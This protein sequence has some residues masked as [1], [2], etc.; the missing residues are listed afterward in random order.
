MAGQTFAADIRKHAD[1]TK[2]QMRRV[3]IDSFQD[4]MELCQTSARGITA[5]GTR[6]EGRI[7]VVSSDL[8]NS[9][10]S[11]LGGGVSEMGPDSY[12]TTLSGLKLGDSAQFAWTMEYARRVESGFTG[13]DE[14]G[15]TYQQ[16][17]WHFVSLNAAKFPAI[18][19]KNAKMRRGGGT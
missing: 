11:S 10:V 7:P 3:A 5:G 8:I 15:R 6:I 1:L 4:V 16:E 2:M 12:V 13:T 19:E 14:E 18:V 17:G 9:L